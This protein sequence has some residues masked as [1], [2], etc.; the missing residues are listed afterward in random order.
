M[1]H[2]DTN[3]VIAL[4]N[5]RPAAVRPRF[6]A[7]VE[8]G[9]TIVISAIVLHE[10]VYG[11]ALSPR[12]EAN[13]EKITLLLAAGKVTCLAFDDEDAPQAA[14]IREGLKRMGMPI[15]P[16]DLLIAAQARRHGAT[17]VTA[18]SR[19]FARVPGLSAVDWTLP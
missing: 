6:D 12:R 19:E 10:L 4:L 11:A 14:E 17:L 8:A 3:V 7:A 16:Y 18:N 13:M 5:G 15:G 9:E 1:I 2:L